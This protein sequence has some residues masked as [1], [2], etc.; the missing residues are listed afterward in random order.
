MGLRSRK[1]Y[2]MAMASDGTV[3]V[4]TTVDYVPGSGGIG[5]L[6]RKRPGHDWTAPTISAVAT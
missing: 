2:D 1:Y 5:W 6:Y 4:T 3:F